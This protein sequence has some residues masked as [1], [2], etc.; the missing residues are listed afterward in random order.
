VDP[1][2][3]FAYAA[4]NGSNN[5]SAYTINSAAGTL[6]AVPG[7]PFAV[8]Q[9]PFP[10]TVDPTG[11]FAYVP[12]SFSSYVSAYTISPTGALTAV[13]GSPFFVGGEST[14][15]TVDPTGRFAYV[16]LAPY[17]I[18]PS[19][20][21][22]TAIPGSIYATATAVR[23]V[24]ITSRASSS[25]LPAIA[26][27]VN[28][29]DFQSGPISPGEIITITGSGLGP[30]T[31][32]G[33]ALDPTGKVATTLGGVQVLIG[34]TPAPLTYV[35][36]TQ[37]NCVVPYEIQGLISASVQVSYQG[38]ASAVLQTPAAPTAP[39]LFTADGSGKGPAAAFNQ[40]GSYNSATNPAAKG[41]IVVL[42]MT[43]EG[44]TSPAGVTGRVTT[45]SPTP[46]LTPGPMFFPFVQL[47]GQFILSKFYGEAPGLVS[48]V[49]QLNVQIPTV[50]PSGSLPLQIFFNL[51]TGSQTSSQTGVTI[52]VQ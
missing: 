26:A 10:V 11:Q 30:A 43:G 34:G 18:N 29:A 51:D 1:S 44:Q 21:A 47:D 22:L 13:P 2:G 24:V 40:D 52:S 5:V 7:S 4:N 37:I 32:V 31:P 49:M 15:V 36:A 45:V 20:G 50:V 38:Q 9:Y 46:P 35:S 25:P 12:S 17:S 16:G 8:G 33:L 39:A 23:S 6:T 48:G 27:L 41:S 3:H 28:A 42:F 14:S 19:T